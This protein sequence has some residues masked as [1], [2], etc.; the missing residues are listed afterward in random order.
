MYLNHT[1]VPGFPLTLRY[2]EE[3]DRDF[4]TEVFSEVWEGIPETDRNAILT[5]GYGHLTV[6]ILQADG[7]RAGVDMSSEIRLSRV[8]IDSYPRNV[9]I[10]MVARELAHKVDGFFHPTPPALAKELRQDA[11]RRVLSILQR[12]G[13]PARA[14][15]VHTP[16][17]Q[18]RIQGA[19]ELNK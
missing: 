9:V 13:Y 18:A 16:A 8:K 11:K 7:H 19:K 5:R 1:L 12:W 3:R 17:D 14:K 15:P 4:L 10:H 2:A 6:D